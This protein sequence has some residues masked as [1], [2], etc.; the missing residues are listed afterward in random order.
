MASHLYYALFQI[1]LV[2]V[3]QKRVNYVPLCYGLSLLLFFCRFHFSERNIICTSYM[4]GALR[5]V[6]DWFVNSL[7]GVKRP[8]L[9][10]YCLSCTLSWFY[11]EGCHSRVRMVRFDVMLLHVHECQ[12]GQVHMDQ[13]SS[14]GNQRECVPPKK[15]L[16]SYDP[17]PVS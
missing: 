9:F 11:L 8:K 14:C 1:F 4:I 2:H 13:I 17:G 16:F 6:V 7:V 12:N 5:L 3:L 10:L 15:S